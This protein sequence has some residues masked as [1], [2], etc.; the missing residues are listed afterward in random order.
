MTLYPL[1]KETAK[2]S[3]LSK[4]G[5]IV[6]AFVVLLNIA[7]RCLTE[8]GLNWHAVL[9]LSCDGLLYLLSVYV[10]FY[11]MA[12]TARRDAK[13]RKQYED[14]LS[15]SQKAV[16]K[17]KPYRAH[18]LTYIAEYVKNDVLSRKKAHLDVAGIPYDDYQNR[19]ARMSKRALKKA[20]LTPW[21][22]KSIYRANK[23]K[24]Q[25][26]TRESLLCYV[27]SQP[28]QNPLL[29]PKRLMSRRYSKALL[30]TTI[31]ALF[32]AQIVFEAQMG[33]DIKRIFVESLLRVGLLSWTALRG[34]ATGEKTIELDSIAYLV[35][36]TD[37]LEEFVLWQENNH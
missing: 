33:G 10:T 15:Q 14:A 3:L 34:Y 18:L 2:Q 29:S 30:P 37:F 35:A 32:S 4:A 7:Y 27:E 24:P 21:E 13:Q 22:R 12:D 16:E 1:G 28:H 20:G 36:K 5:Y 25:Q 17:A 26:I 11:A 6:F 19:Y 9:A 8:V 31:F 23:V